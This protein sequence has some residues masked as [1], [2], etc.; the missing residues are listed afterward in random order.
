MLYG[1]AVL[2]VSLL[3][4]DLAMTTVTHT[5]DGGYDPCAP[6]QY[7]T[8]DAMWYACLLLLLDVELLVLVVAFGWVYRSPIVWSTMLAGI[9]TCYMLTYVP[10]VVAELL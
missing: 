8:F 4:T 3:H 6:L 9:W 2:V 7:V 5:V 10:E 1:V